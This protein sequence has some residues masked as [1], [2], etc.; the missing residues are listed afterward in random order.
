MPGIFINDFSIASRLGMDAEET[1]VSLTSPSPPIPDTVF[2]LLDKTTTQIAELPSPPVGD[3]VTR[4]NRIADHLLSQMSDKI[5]WMK[6][7]F[8]SH[9]IG[10]I[11]GTSTTGIEEATDH[12]GISPRNRRMV[13]LI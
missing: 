10:V 2:E 7:H 1:R 13:R 6:S 12:L 4:T 5:E 11:I 9:R 3:G 8:D